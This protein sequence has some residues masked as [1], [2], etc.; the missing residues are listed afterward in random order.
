MKRLVGRQLK[1]RKGYKERKGDW[2][3]RRIVMLNCWFDVIDVVGNWNNRGHCLC[4]QWN[5]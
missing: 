4:K 1:L 3:E 2:L 5:G